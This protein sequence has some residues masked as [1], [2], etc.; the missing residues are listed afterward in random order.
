MKILLIVV[1]LLLCYCT[2]Y[3]QEILSSVF[4]L[5]QGISKMDALSEIQSK[6]NISDINIYNTQSKTNE[7][8][9]I[10]FSDQVNYVH[11]E[12]FWI[13]GYR[14][15]NLL[16]FT[17]DKLWEQNVRLF[18]EP[19]DSKIC[20]EK[21]S[22]FIKAFSSRDYITKPYI[23][24]DP[25]T[26]EK[27]GEGSIITKRPPLRQKADTS[28]RIDVFYTI[29]YESKFDSAQKKRIKTGKVDDYELDAILYE[30]KF[31]K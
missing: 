28:W 19:S 8:N 29:E 16:V 7:Q 11:N 4:L 30:M 13:G 1:N 24:T 5:K 12:N 21:F 17:N 15:I 20:S 9:Q 31:N 2:A 27:I 26:N 6:S 14:N 10:Y 25:E 23:L 18:F 3:S 22:D